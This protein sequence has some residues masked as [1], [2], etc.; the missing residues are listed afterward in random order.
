M[1]FVEFKPI[2]KKLVVE[3]KQ[4]TNI[5]HPE[6]S[7][8]TSANSAVQA[9]KS[10]E[11]VISNADKIS[12]KWDGGIALFFGISPEGKFFIND[13]WMPAGFYAYSPNDWYRYDTQMKKSK[14]ARTG[15]Y[16]T[17]A[18]IWKGLQQSVTD[19]AIYKG[20]LM[21]HSDNGP[22]QPVNG[23]YEFKPTT[24]TYKIP[25]NSALGKLI[26]N[27]VGVVVVHQRNNSPWDGKTGLSNRGNVAIISPKAGINFS[28]KSPTKLIAAARNAVV[29]QAPIAEQ[30]LNGMANPARAALKIYFNKKIT[31]QTTE[32]LL[33]WLE[34]EVSNK[35]YIFLKDYL[36]KNAKGMK[37]L[38]NVWN[39]LYRLKQNLTAQLE[40]QVQG[41]SQTVNNS[42]GGEGFV[43]PTNMG[44]MK[45]VD[46][47]QFG[48]AHFN[49]KT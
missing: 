7:I 16:E 18:V 46:R 22:L 34:H 1:K 5:P 32:D 38:E 28:L 35:Q 47:Q 48:T 2:A 42:P 12:I 14:T 40:S 20:D 15:L 41:F 6:D 3:T 10:L 36:H 33:P 11:D 19:K 44:L 43:A 31:N 25:V 39:S 21:A 24:V 29:K 13:K 49:K 17:L 8:F 37:A 23:N 45:L 26:H 27:K 4:P 30:F 9:E